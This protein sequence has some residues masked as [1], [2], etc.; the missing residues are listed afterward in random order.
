MFDLPEKCTVWNAG[1][2]DG[3]G[4]ISWLGPYVIDC[5]IAHKAQTFTDINGDQVVS[6]SV[7][8]ANSDLI[9]PKSQVF[10]GESLSPTPIEK[11]NDVRQTSRIP[12]GTNLAK[13]WFA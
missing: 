6:T 7:M 11:S 8:Y 13:H 1:S 10:F 5:R 4:G 3:F 12:S 2:N 9:N